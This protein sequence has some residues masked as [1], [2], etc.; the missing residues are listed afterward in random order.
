MRYVMICSAAPVNPN[1]F[2][3]AVVYGIYRS[4]PAD[5]KNRPA[6]PIYKYMRKHYHRYVYGV[7]SR[8]NYTRPGPLSSSQVVVEGYCIQF[9]AM[10]TPETTACEYVIAAQRQRSR[11]LWQQPLFNSPL[12]RQA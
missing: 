2:A 10:Q 6:V 1:R 4:S 7:L 11:Q 8:T 5:V 3:M 9:F 12:A